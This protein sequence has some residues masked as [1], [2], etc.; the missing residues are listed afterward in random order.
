MQIMLIMNIN[1]LGYVNNLKFNNI[2]LLLSL[3]LR[4]KKYITCPI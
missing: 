1:L 2:R 4:F 3:Q